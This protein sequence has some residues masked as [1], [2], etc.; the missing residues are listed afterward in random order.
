MILS[1]IFSPNQCLNSEENDYFSSN[2]HLFSIGGEESIRRQTSKNATRKNSS[3]KMVPSG[4]TPESRFHTI[5]DKSPSIDGNITPG[6]KVDM[7]HQTK[8]LNH[9]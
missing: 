3:A 1:V 4:F 9:M 8:M 5:Y 7:A 6:T 2:K